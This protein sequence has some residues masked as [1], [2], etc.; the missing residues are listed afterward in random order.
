VQGALGLRVT[1]P[2]GDTDWESAFA[3]RLALQILG[4]AGTAYPKSCTQHNRGSR[5]PRSSDYGTS[6]FNGYDTV[7]LDILW[8]I[9]E[10]DLPPLI[11]RLEGLLSV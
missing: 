5:G 6:S 7:D 4:E 10:K 3:L 8:K 2:R 9:A 1:S 11:S